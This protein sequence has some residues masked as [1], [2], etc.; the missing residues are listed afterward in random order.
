MTAVDLLALGGILD[1]IAVERARQEDI[2]EAKR[3]QGIDWRS[4]ADPDMGGGDPMRLA[5]LAEEF[6]EV[7]NAVLETAYGSDDDAHLRTELIQVAAVA[8]AWAE[9]IDARTPTEGDPQ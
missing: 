6:G 9:A 1:A 8:A 5:V 2:G 7:A 3:A 4:C